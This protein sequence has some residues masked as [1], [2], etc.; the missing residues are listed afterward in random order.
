MDSVSPL[1][2][3]RR[4]VLRVLL[5]LTVAGGLLFGVINIQR[6]ALM[7]AG[8]EFLMAGF[9]ALL[10]WHLRYTRRLRLWMTTFLLAFFTSMLV[11]LG[12]AAATP[13][14]FVWVLL[15]PLLSHL[16]LGRHAGLVVSVV[17]LGLAALIYFARIR[18]EGQLL[19]LMAVANV[20]FCAAALLLLSY[21]YEAGRE[22]VEARLQRLASTDPLTGLSNR[23]A[24]QDALQRKC[25]EAEREGSQ[26]SVAL[27]DFDRFKQIND[28]H[29]H[30]AGDWV[31]VTFAQLLQQR[32]RGSDLPARWGGEEFLILLSGTGPDNARHV[33][34]KLR[35][36]TAELVV[37]TGSQALQSTISV[38]LSS[39]PEDAGELNEL[40]AVADR[41]L[42]L[43]KAAGRDRVVGAAEE[44]T[45]E[46]G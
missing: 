13:T 18:G 41:R 37:D 26:F 16:L 24:M 27:I 35:V 8:V 12:T 43:A 10:F 6:E 28:Q 11:A 32:L 36:A 22:Q 44:L 17:Y 29:G 1:N 4:A 33:M 39:F 23:G 30:E 3:Q 2:P 34:E 7:L 21:Y 9:A 45:L 40:L 15:I 19:E 25:L 42:Y 5:L 46:R 14:V 38:G 31:L 20:L